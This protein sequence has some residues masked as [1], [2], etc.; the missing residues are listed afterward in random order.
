[1]AEKL[2]T[3]IDLTFISYAKAETMFEQEEQMTAEA[4]IDHLRA[5]WGRFL[6]VYVKTWDSKEG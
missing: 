3:L 6:E 5:N 1:V 4:F 2:K